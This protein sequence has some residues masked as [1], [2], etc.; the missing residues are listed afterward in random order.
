V[1]QNSNQSLKDKREEVEVLAV[2]LRILTADLLK[3]Q[4]N[5]S[6]NAPQQSTLQLGMEQRKYSAEQERRDLD[7]LIQILTE[8]K[9]RVVAERDRIMQELKLPMIIAD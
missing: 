4:R 2:E 5:F 3:L 6:T 1:V 8:A 9:H 7:E